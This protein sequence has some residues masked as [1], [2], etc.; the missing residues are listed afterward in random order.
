MSLSFSAAD[1]PTVTVTRAPHPFTADVTA[2]VHGLAIGGKAIVVPVKDEKEANTVR[3]IAREAGASAPKPFT[4][5]ALIAPS[6][7]A[8]TV[9]LWA[10]ARQAR[11]GAGR[12]PSK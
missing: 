5:R 7:K 12:K 3:R 1:V 11:P 10:V 9:T 8:F 2:A 6:G 4:C